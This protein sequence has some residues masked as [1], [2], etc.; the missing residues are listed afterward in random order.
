MNVMVELSDEMLL[1]S[2]HRAIEL[3][4]EQDFIALL[5]VEIRKRK[6][7]SPVHAVLH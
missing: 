1:D 6:L 5:L 3:Q 7:H 2:Y 4:L